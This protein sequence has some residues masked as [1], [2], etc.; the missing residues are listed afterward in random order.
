MKP[1]VERLQQEYGD[2]IEFRAH[3]IESDRQ[4]VVIAQ[5]LGVQFPPT[6]VFVNSDGVVGARL[7]GEIAE[8][9]MRAQLDALK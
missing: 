2:R 8:T 4:A 3:N 9:D 1:L 5:S 7:T 6:Y